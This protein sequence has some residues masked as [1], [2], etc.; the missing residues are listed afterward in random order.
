[1]KT[2]FS[3]LLRKNFRFLA[4]FGFIIMIFLLLAPE[5]ARADSALSQSF[6]AQGQN[7][8]AAAGKGL[9][10]QIDPVNPDSGDITL[11]IPGTATSIEQAFLYWAGN[12]VNPGGDGTV[13][14]SVNGGPVL[15]LTADRTFGPDFWVTG[16]PDKFHYVYIEDVTSLIQIGTNTYSISDVG[17]LHHVYG[18][19]LVVVYSD[20]SL[21]VNQITIND[22]LDAAYFGFPPPRGPNTEVS[23]FQFPAA[24]SDRNLDFIIVAGGVNITDVRPNSIW[25]QTGPSALSDLVDQPGATEIP[26]FPLNSNDG[27]SWDTYTATI[28]VPPGDTFA[29][30]QIESVSDEPGLQG[31]SLLWVASGA[32]ISI[33]EEITTTPTSTFTDT[34]T[35]T[36][37]DT[38]TATSTDTNTVTPTGS[39]TVTPSA[40]PT[41]TPTVTPTGSPSPTATTPTPTPTKVNTRTPTPTESFIC[42][43]GDICIP[44]TGFSPGQFTSLRAQPKDKLYSNFGDLSLEIPELS[45]QKSILGVPLQSDGWDVTWLSNQ[46][47]YL[48][49]DCVPNLARQHRAY[50]S[51]V[52][53]RWYTRSFC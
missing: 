42:E 22:G 38:P 15:T 13:N 36:P 4:I 26:D 37:T 8:I 14:F 18:A 29:C 11:T 39:P 10:T 21:T 17:P 31:A 33:P 16:N 5:L 2:I 46:I 50:R 35:A 34:P 30:F 27:R 9:Y 52:S 20:P 1:M 48:E 44:V 51:C 32:S 49:F 12:D 19:G 45:L 41:D 3:Q 6:S 40:T 28:N 24:I 7:G 43:P 53:L 25:Y 23:C 47:G